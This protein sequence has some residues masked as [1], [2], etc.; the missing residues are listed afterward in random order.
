VSGDTLYVGGEFTQAGGKASG[1]VA[2]VFLE[3][4]PPLEKTGSR[5]TAFFRGIP[6]GSY[7]I[8]RSVGLDVWETLARRYAGKNGGIDFTDEA[9]PGTRAFYRAVPVE[10]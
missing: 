4:V 7:G 8:E 9:A 5:A 6:S 3:G 1:N 2:K 10:P